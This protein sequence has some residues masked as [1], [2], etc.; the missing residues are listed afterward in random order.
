[1]TLRTQT[2]GNQKSWNLEELKSGFEHFYKQHYRYPTAH[3]ID[4]YN[5]LP[6]ARSIERRFGGLVAIRKL[7]KLNSD[8]DFRAGKH[9]SERARTINVRAHKTKILVYEFLIEKFNKEFI[10]REFFFTDDKR[11]RSDFFVYDNQEGFCIDV[12][13]PKDRRNLIGCLNNKLLKYKTSDMRQYPVI[14]LQMNPDLNQDILNAVIKNKKNMWP[15]GQEIMSWDKFQN[16]IKSR[17]PLSIK[18]KPQ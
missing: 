12:F 8:P 9:S 14:F 11:T 16:F 4:T 15:S 7:L 2:K 5:Y 6:S 1:M 17:K 13:Y 10:H 3:E 18:N